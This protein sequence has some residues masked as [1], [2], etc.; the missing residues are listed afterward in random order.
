MSETTFSGGERWSIEGAVTIDS[1]ARVFDASRHA[2]LPA[3]GVV[4]L[5]RVHAVDSAA[6]ALLLAWKRRAVAEGKTLAFAAMPPNLTALA[7]LY[8]V[9][10]LLV[11]D[12][13][14]LPAVEA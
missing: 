3:S 14:R 7:E 11:T 6:V 8:G 12:G 2:A 1:A 10:S 4:A 5:E 13:A 9:E